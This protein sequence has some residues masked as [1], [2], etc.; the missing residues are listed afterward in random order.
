[1]SC[2]SSSSH[3]SAILINGLQNQAC[4]NFIQYIA[5]DQRMQLVNALS[6]A[7]FFSFQIDGRTDSANV[8]E[9]VFLVLYFNP[10]SMEK[11]MSVIIS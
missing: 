3:N 9:E 1:M 4:A 5:H 8:E 11:Y 6:K 2:F 10:Y 7:N